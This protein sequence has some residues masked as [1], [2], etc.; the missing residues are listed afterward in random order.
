MSATAQ[1]GGELHLNEIRAGDILLYRPRRPNAVQKKISNATNSPYTHAAICIE[2]GTIAE[3]VAW[4]LLTGVRKSCLKKSLENS[5]CVAVLRSQLTFGHNRENKLR[6]FVEEVRKDGRFY[7][8]IAAYNFEKNSKHYFENQ[9]SLIRE[10]YGKY[11]PAEEFAKQSFFCSAFVVA[12]YSVVGI[13]TETAQIAYLPEAFSPARLYCDPTFGWLLGYIV[14][15]GGSVPN[16]D[17]LLTRTT[18]WSQ[19]A[20]ARWWA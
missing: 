2:R 5:L 15:E 19:S 12:C 13:I 14:P 11:T 1:T 3:S 6:S 17:P 7:N 9:L 16:D 8:L 10:N 20:S 4:P 18:L